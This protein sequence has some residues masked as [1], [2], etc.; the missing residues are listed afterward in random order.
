MGGLSLGIDR[1]VDG[2]LARVRAAGIGLAGAM[3]VTSAPAPALSAGGGG[4]ASSQVGEVHI[5]VRQLPGED[6][7]QLARRVAAE[8]AKLRRT[9]RVARDSSYEDRD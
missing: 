7:D 1:T 3:A 4:G 6:G 8:V 2:P 9:D 5:H